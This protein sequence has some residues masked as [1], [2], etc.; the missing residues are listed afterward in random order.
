MENSEIVKIGLSRVNLV[1][2]NLAAGPIQNDFQYGHHK[3]SVASASLKALSSIQHVRYS[4]NFQ[5]KT[6]VQCTHSLYFVTFAN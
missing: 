3:L 6:P 1:R 5:P 4:G 2:S